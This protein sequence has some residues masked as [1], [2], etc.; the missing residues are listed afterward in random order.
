MG[1]RGPDLDDPKMLKR[2]FAVIQELAA[3][4]LILAYHDR[5]DGGLF[6]TLCEMAFAGSHR[7]AHRPGRP[8]W[9]VTT[10]RSCSTRSLGAVLQV[11]HTDTDDVLKALHD[12]GLGQHSYVFGALT[13]DDT[14]SFT[15]HG[16]VELSMGRAELQRAWSETTRAHAGA[17]GQ[18]GVCPRGVRPHSEAN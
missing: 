17:A 15:R 1:R 16:D 5:S 4:G 10:R 18:S 8:G 14:L 7:P 13:D 3:D 2:F 11:Q 12:A 9:P 6:V